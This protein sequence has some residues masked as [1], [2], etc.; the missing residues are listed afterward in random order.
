VPDDAA[1]LEF[2]IC[3]V[4]TGILDWTLSETDTMLTYLNENIVVNTLA[5][6]ARPGVAS[7]GETAGQPARQ[8]EIHLD[9]VRLQPIN[10]LIV[11]P[12]VVGAATST[13]C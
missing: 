11:T 10:L 8:F 2:T 1:A 13:C 3:N 5:I 12:D 4:G 7:R 9:R 6:E